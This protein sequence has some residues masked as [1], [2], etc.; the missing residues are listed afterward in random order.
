MEGLPPSVYTRS[1]E[2]SASSR[3]VGVSGRFAKFGLS[4]GKAAIVK[5]FLGD[6]AKLKSFRTN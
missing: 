3:I 1:G 6:V 4:E 5:E 2:T